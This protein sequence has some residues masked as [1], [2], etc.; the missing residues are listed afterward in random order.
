[1]PQRH[2]SAIP[3]HAEKPLN[4][5]LLGSKSPVE[6]LTA[7]SSLVRFGRRKMPDFV[8]SLRRI[9]LDRA[10]VS[11]APNAVELPA[12]STV[13]A[14]VMVIDDGQDIV[15]V[16]MATSVWLPDA[17]PDGIDRN[18]PLLA[19]AGLALVGIARN[20][21]QRRQFESRSFSPTERHKPDSSPHSRD[22]ALGSD[23]RRVVLRRCTAQR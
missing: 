13:A 11:S 21:Y 22:A 17:K 5:C 6:H 12:K 18:L 19:A 14:R 7:A 15:S 20:E 10:G 16:F 4:S 23:A 3:K 8:A 1:M 2:L 9:D